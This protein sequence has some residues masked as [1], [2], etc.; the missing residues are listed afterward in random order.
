MSYKYY[1]IGLSQNEFNKSFNQF[2][3]DNKKFFKILDE[4]AEE[5]KI[6]IYKKN[7]KLNINNNKNFNYVIVN[8]EGKKLDKNS[9]NL[10]F[11]NYLN[12]IDIHSI[13]FMG[14]CLYLIFVIFRTNEVNEDLINF[15]KNGF[16]S[17]K[18]GKYIRYVTIPIVYEEK[19][20]N[21]Y[22]GCYSGKNLN[23]KWFGS[24]MI[25][26]ILEE[27]QKNDII[28]THVSLKKT[29]KE[30]NESILSNYES[31]Y[32]KSMVLKWKSE[33]KIKFLFILIIIVMLIHFF[34]NK[35]L[36]IFPCF[37]LILTLLSFFIKYRRKLDKINKIKLDISNIFAFKE[38][39]NYILRK[40]YKNQ[41][42]S[43]I[44]L[45]K[46][47]T[48][49]L[50]K[51]LA[52]KQNCYVILLDDFYEEKVINIINTKE[53]KLKK[54][55]LVLKKENNDYLTFVKDDNFKMKVKLLN[56]FKRTF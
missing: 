6:D 22:I 46:Y 39:L 47:S 19:K 23:S 33:K 52:N 4:I 45:D 31:V 9:L 15:I 17:D 14:S 26:W 27:L 36:F 34:H 54:E 10:V 48:T 20:E 16:N 30:N 13:Q 32:N 18:K 53:S 35:N 28:F 12:N 29:E 56:I 8:V 41:L 49:D 42:D 5:I 43:F 7:G 40:Y 51:L 24:D 2:V 55:I 38:K 11:S 44:I 3:K 37:L 50:N 1:R 21:L 25:V